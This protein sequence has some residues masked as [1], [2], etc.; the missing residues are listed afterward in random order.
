[1]D[2]ELPFSTAVGFDWSIA[3]EW[4]AGCRAHPL[5]QNDFLREEQSAFVP[6]RLLEI[7]PAS[8]TDGSSG[9]KEKMR[10]PPDVRLVDTANMEWIHQEQLYLTLS[11]FSGD[12]AEDHMISR[13]TR[14][15]LEKLKIAIPYAALPPL[16]KDA[17][18]ITNQLGFSYLWVDALCVMEDSEEE[19]ESQH[20]QRGLV[21][22][23]SVCTISMSA[24][25]G[26][27][28]IRLTSK[29]ETYPTK[30][31]KCPRELGG[32][33]FHEPKYTI[34]TLFLRHVDFRALNRWSW[35]Y[36]QE[37]LL[38]RR[39][40]HIC[41]KTEILFECNTMRASRH[42]NFQ[43]GV[44]Y[45]FPPSSSS[46]RP[47]P[48]TPQSCVLGSMGSDNSTKTYTYETRRK[49]IDERSGAFKFE[50]VVVTKDHFPTTEEQLEALQ[51]SIAWRRHRGA[52]QRVLRRT[53]DLNSYVGYQPT[54]EATRQ[55]LEERLGRHN[56]W[57]DMVEAHSRSSSLL[58][59]GMMDRYRKR[60][61]GLNGIVDI[62]VQ[63][64]KQ[65]N[66][67]LVLGPYVAGLW[68][69]MMPFNL[70]WHRADP[71]IVAL[72]KE[73]DPSFL[74]EYRG[75]VLHYQAPP[76]SLDIRDS[77]PSEHLMPTWSWAS[78]DGQVSHSLPSAL[79]GRNKGE[80]A[81]GLVARS[82]KKLFS[83]SKPPQP[84]T[85]Q[86][87]T[88]NMITP[89]I[90][91]VELY[92]HSTPIRPDFVAGSGAQVLPSELSK[93]RLRIRNLYPLFSLPAPW[94]GLKGIR[95]FYDSIGR[96]HQAIHPG[97]EMFADSTGGGGARVTRAVFGLPVVEVSNWGNDPM[98]I[99]RSKWK[100]QVHGLALRHV[101]TLNGRGDVYERVGY[102]QTTDQEVI[103]QILRVRSSRYDG[104][105]WLQ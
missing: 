105:V 25:A 14:S 70:L 29:L 101:K 35:S 55:Q 6:R 83:P 20:Y 60:L 36:F 34:D 103:G 73:A 45:T 48:W 91:P 53:E 94:E 46:S 76:A 62:V 79:E 82:L 40:L 5:C 63:T 64:H 78:V 86:P 95:I 52:L 26:Q 19:Q 50:T 3:R 72:P 32:P 66:F 102:F 56:A 81:T 1:M 98:G 96:L 89:L 24:P 100:R 23:N 93:L 22:S 28:G 49:T 87:Q 30:H 74:A 90:D 68:L 4:I 65:D 12:I 47:M 54:P 42:P 37:R 18:A 80:T 8:S 99:D 104:V 61:L 85:A 44:P 92:D 38:S 10:Y 31:G 27:P 58:N 2:D 84:S 39:V 11:H 33:G 43:K 69:G 59:K 57:L 21:F 97:N 75:A 71:V 16:F 88:W 7:I 17:I 77:L 51:Y 13:L 15:N 9:E 67:Q 41:D